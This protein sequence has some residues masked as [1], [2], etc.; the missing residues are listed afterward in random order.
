MSTLSLGIT[1]SQT[2]GPFF[3]FGTEWIANED[4]VEEGSIGAIILKGMV[5]D[6]AGEP[7]PD[8]MIEIWQADANGKF[9]P[10]T[11]ESWMGFARR[12]TDSIGSYRVRTV[13]PGQVA[14]SSGEMQAP[15]I[16]MVVFARGLLKPVFT[17]VYFGDESQ[18]N[19]NDPLLTAIDDESA[20][21]TLFAVLE[22]DSSYLFDVRLQDSPKGQQTQ[23]FLFDE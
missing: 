11:A 21:S 12:L 14:T 5:Y 23:F 19:A 2:I 3:R 7:V 9:P 20:R 18:S 6:G 10:D 4:L 17:R 22:A 8:A 16:S 15:H 1:P 13:K